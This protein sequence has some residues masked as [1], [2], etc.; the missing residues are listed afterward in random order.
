MPTLITDPY[1]KLTWHKDGF[2]RPWVSRKFRRGSGG[3]IIHEL[4]CDICGRW[5]NYSSND[6]PKIIGQKRWNFLKLRPHHCGNSFCEDYFQ[7]YKEHQ[8]ETARNLERNCFRLFKRLQK[9]R[10]VV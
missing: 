5:Y 4:R 6:I 2:K 9:K 3:E 1:K 8:E 7:R 10:L